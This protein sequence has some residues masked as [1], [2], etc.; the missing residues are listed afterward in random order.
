MLNKEFI[1]KKIPKIEDKLLVSKILDKAIKAENSVRETHS[2]FLDPYQAALVQKVLSEFDNI[3]YSFDGGYEGAERSIVVFRPDFVL[4]EDDNTERNRYFKLISVS[5]NRKNRFSHRDCLGS[6]M[7]LGIKR[8]KV[9]D[10][11]VY[12]D[13]CDIIVLNE[14]AEYIRYSLTSVGSTRVAV[15][16]KMTDQLKAPEPKIKEINTTL[17]SLR[18]DCVASAGFGIS[19]SKAADFIK[20]EKLNLNWEMINSLTRQVKEGDTISIRGKGKLVLEKIN[21]KTK[22]DRISVLIKKYV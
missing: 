18:M 14:V 1:L 21:G 16:I 2:D 8:E 20:A 10:I 19:R 13:S 5:L 9:G 17:A 22:K 15:E 4:S 7:G 6:L 3:D 11:L 12:T